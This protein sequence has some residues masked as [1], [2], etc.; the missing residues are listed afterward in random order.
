MTN[1]IKRLFVNPDL[2]ILQAMRIIDKGAA[3]IGLVVDQ[4]RH[5]LGTLT[6]G[7]IRR[8]LLSGASLESK[9]ADLMNTKYR[10]VDSKEDKTSILEMMRRDVLRQIPVIDRERKVVALLTLE[11]LI[12]PPSLNNAAVIMA[13]GQGKRLRPYT[14]NC[15]KPMLEIGGRP[16]LEILLEQCKESGFRKFFF[17]VNYL[18][19]KIEHLKM[20]N[21][22]VCLLNI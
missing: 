17:S 20:A 3:Q 22:G 13:G 5:L 8:G 19:E 18:K 2:D 21:A 7:D 12:N 16:M 11:E 10:S 1:D 14:N 4:E 6:D 15:P 9:V